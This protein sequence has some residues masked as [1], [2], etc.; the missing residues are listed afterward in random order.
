MLVNRHSR[1][2]G[3]TARP[4]D[5]G[6]DAIRRRYRVRYAAAA[7]AI[8]RSATRSVT[9]RAESPR[10]GTPPPS[11]RS[12]P[13]HASSRAAAGPRSAQI[14]AEK[15][16]FAGAQAA[17]QRADLRGE[18]N[19]SFNLEAL[20]NTHASTAEAALVQPTTHDSEA[21]S[22]ARPPDPP[23]AP[24]RQGDE[25]ESAPPTASVAPPVP[26]RSSSGN[27]R[28]ARH[29]E[30]PR[31]R[32]AL[33]LALGLPVLAFAAAFAVGSSAGTAPAAPGREGTPAAAVSLPAVTVVDAADVPSRPTSIVRTQGW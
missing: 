2:E 12:T 4:G 28:P 24:V 20:L 19:A 30:R 11:R 5:R 32:R 8:T 10:A 16:D 25:G 18:A 3:G 33:V 1:A 22:S 17:F 23:L 15:G 21:E 27:P 14:L 26:A 31:R 7:V 6:R 9:P 13:G 29:R